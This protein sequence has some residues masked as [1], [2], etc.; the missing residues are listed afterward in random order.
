MRS[1]PRQVGM[2]RMSDFLSVF[3]NGRLAP[4]LCD[5]FR[6]LLSGLEDETLSQLLN[7][8]DKMTMNH[9]KSTST[10]TK[11][12]CPNYRPD[13]QED[14]ANQQAKR[15][16]EAEAGECEALERKRRR[17]EETD[18][19]ERAALER[20]RKREEV[21]WAAM[22]L[23]YITCAAGAHGHEWPILVYA[24]LRNLKYGRRH[25]A[26]RAL[27]LCM[28]EAR[29][30]EDEDVGSFRSALVSIGTGAPVRIWVS[31][32][33]RRAD[34][35]LR[36]H[37][38]EPPRGYVLALDTESSFCP[39]SHQQAQ[40]IVHSVAWVV[41]NADGLLE[42]APHF[43]VRPSKDD[44]ALLSMASEV[45]GRVGFRG[46]F[47]LK[48]LLDRGVMIEDVATRLEAALDPPT[49]TVSTLVGYALYN[50]LDWIAHARGP[51]G[52]L[53][54]PSSM[55]LF[56]PMLLGP[57]NDKGRWMRREQ[58]MEHFRMASSVRPHTAPSDCMDA[59]ALYDA[60]SKTAPAQNA[61]AGIGSCIPAKSA[62][63]A[64]DLRALHDV[65]CPLHHVLRM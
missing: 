13:Q 37:L 29:Q 54:V 38:V 17:E 65:H 6:H 12:K 50:D 52:A 1:V 56:D 26:E 58:M 10:P 5:L 47:D 31:P 45:D 20:K 2:C 24:A 14:A 4:A 46:K 11:S 61:C 9:I 19:F 7:D 22:S 59:L 3:V 44:E 64:S 41:R 36:S 62:A 42:D 39:G 35:W 55:I 60:I 49:H 16:E 25:A 28:A 15:Q 51:D 53:S 30:N 18:A 43:L 8:E 63:V 48:K 21:V 57:R 27:C 34:E 33:N 40:R 32:G 23:D